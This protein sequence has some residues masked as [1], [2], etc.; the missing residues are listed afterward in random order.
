MIRIFLLFFPRLIK[1][2]QC[3]Y[4]TGAATRISMSM[5]NYFR[6]KGPLNGCRIMRI[7][8]VS[9]NLSPYLLS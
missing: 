1:N 8:L 2:S 7:F 3:I 9:V 4:G 6:V 5:G